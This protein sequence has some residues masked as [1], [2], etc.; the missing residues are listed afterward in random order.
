MA[1]DALAAMGANLWFAF[2]QGLPKL[3]V[4][5]ILLIVGFIVGKAVGLV[6]KEILVR[7]GVDKYLKKEEHLKFKA[8][9]VFDVISRWLVYVAFI[10]AAVGALE[11][12][13]LS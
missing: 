5:I 10:W 1:V 12:G 7:V 3:I 2:L 11:I 8:S 13:A 4:A 6:V 9:S